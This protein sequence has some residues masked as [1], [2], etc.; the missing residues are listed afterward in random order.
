MGK[1]LTL[2]ANTDEI[3]VAVRSKQEHLDIDRLARSDG[4]KALPA[5]SH[6]AWSIIEDCRKHGVALRIDADGTL[7]VGRTGAKADEPTQPWQT[8]LTAI[9]AHADA[10][11]RLV[12]AGWHLRADFPPTAAA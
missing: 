1:Y 5:R 8:L 11:A 7:V 6:P 2:L 3:G 10:V 9:E 12:E 4:S